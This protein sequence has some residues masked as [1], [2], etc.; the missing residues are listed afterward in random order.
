MARNTDIRGRLKKELSDDID[1][2]DEKLD[3]ET[4]PS[5]YPIYILEL[6]DAEPEIVFP[7][8]KKD[9]MHVTFWHNTVA[10]R[11]ARK[12]K[13]PLEEILNLPYCQRRARICGKRIYYGEITQHSWTGLLKLKRQIQNA[14]GERGLGFVYEE[15]ES[16]SE[17]DVA[18]F[19][20]L[21][22]S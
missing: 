10:R 3:R 1:R 18:E 2:I 16:R 12:L 6:G 11:V 22:R 13:I 8:G 17:F 20:A 4:K 15:H 19:K 21:S 7:A 5:S 14:V 9:L